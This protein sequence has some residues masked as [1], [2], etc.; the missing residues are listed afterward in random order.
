MNLLRSAAI[1]LL[2]VP[3]SA[4]A[5]DFSISFTWDGLKPCNT[6]RPNVVANPEFVVVGVPE[7]AAGIQFNLTDLDNP[8]YNHGGGWVEITTDGRVPSGAFRYESPCPPGG[9][10]T[11]E[12]TATARTK[13]G[14]GGK[15][16][17]IAKA[18]RPYP[19]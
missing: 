10:N 12:W 17:A 6:G 19:E 16:L 5:E 2:F 4:F 9:Q 3:T 18:R 1:I 11:Y 8:G 13:K 7:G 15:K 14:F